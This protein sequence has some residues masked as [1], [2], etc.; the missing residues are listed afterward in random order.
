VLS[1]VQ[2]ITSQQPD[3]QVLPLVIALAV[4]LFYFVL[5]LTQVVFFRRYGFLAAILVR[6]GF[7]FVWHA[8][9]VH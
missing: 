8:L 6:V 1:S 3:L 4:G 9:Y 7:Y 5:N 2:E